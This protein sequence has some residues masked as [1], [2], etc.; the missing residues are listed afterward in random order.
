[1]KITQ[2]IRIGVQFTTDCDFR[3]SHCL[4]NCGPWGGRTMEEGDVR[5]CADGAVKSGAESFVFT[6]GE[7]LLHPQ[8]LMDCLA[9]ARDA[10]LRVQL[11][12]NAGW[13]DDPSRRTH[14]LDELSAVGLSTLAISCDVFHEPFVSRETIGQL[15]CE[16]RQRKIEPIVLTTLCSDKGN[17]EILRFIAGLQ[18]PVVLGSLRK[19]GRGRKLNSDY[20][21]PSSDQVG[22][23]QQA[24]APIVLVD[25][26]V[27][28]CCGFA[29]L[30]AEGS[31]VPNSAI[32]GNIHT[33]G[34]LSLL[35]EAALP[36][37]SAFGTH[38]IDSLLA[39]SGARE[40]GIGLEDFDCAC[41]ICRYLLSDHLFVERLG[42]LALDSGQAYP[43]ESDKRSVQSARRFIGRRLQMVPG[44]ELIRDV[45][46]Y[47]SLGMFSGADGVSDI[48]CLPNCS[49]NVEFHIIG[50]EL[51]KVLVPVMSG[52][53]CLAEDPDEAAGKDVSGGI[54]ESARRWMIIR[55]AQ[56]GILSPTS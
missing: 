30:A 37:R 34:V 20:F 52:E 24:R 23:C 13:A 50:K 25:G 11:I 14:T 46:H 16:C 7:P 22:V 43:S 29:D 48:L 21:L 49:G 26:T 4:V 31:A 56:L 12:T 1:M 33:R 18:V 36:V 39:A 17:V 19:A 35:Q 28:F 45:R 10:G 5:A 32:L 51:R 42:A 15:V 38:R 44:G 9:Y 8:L 40:K 54:E 27:T 41:D 6:G 55:L 53:S 2:P 47:G 3:C